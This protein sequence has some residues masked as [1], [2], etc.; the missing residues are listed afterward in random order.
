[1]PENS[2]KSTTNRPDLDWSQIKETVMMLSLSV[3][4][5]DRA[6]NE[7]TD[8]VSALT[9]SFTSMAQSASFIDKAGAALTDTKEK[10]TILKNSQII[11]S[12][13]QS[14][15]VAFQ[16]YDKLSQ[17]LNHVCNSLSSLSELVGDSERLFNPSEWK[18]L[19]E[20]I[21][22]KYPTESDKR[23]FD[24]LLAGASVEEALQ[25]S[26]TENKQETDDIELF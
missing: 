26:D 3:A 2:L 21:R 7:G 14:A 8:S 9:D 5:I 18:S 4:Q 20:K 6:M 11:S 25:A 24:A 10:N 15:I 12:Q 1:M 17:R 19:Q 16:F 13:M 23:M 22:S